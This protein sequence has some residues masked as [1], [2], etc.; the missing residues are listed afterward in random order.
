M[1]QNLFNAELFD[2]NKDGFLD[3]IAGGHDWDNEGYNKTPL[4]IYGDGVDFVGNDI[5]RMPQ[6]NIESQGVVTDFEFYDLNDN[7][8]YE[9]IISRTG[10]P[11][12]NTS[13]FYKGW[14]IQVLELIENKY[15]E[16][17]EKFIDNFSGDDTWI[18]W[19][20]MHEKSGVIKLTNAWPENDNFYKEWSLSNGFLK[21]SN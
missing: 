10:D 18:V 17:T 1:T 19:L 6:S 15:V 2:L 12:L 7:G 4:I 8:N 5:F 20:K 14:S 9:I 3:I 16:A 11:Y 13:N 21:R